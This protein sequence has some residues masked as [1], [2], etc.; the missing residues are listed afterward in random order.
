M[1]RSTLLRATATLAVLC[2][3]GLGY[4]PAAHASGTATTPTETV[5]PPTMTASPRGD[6][7]IAM[8]P[9]GILHQPEGRSSLVWTKD[10]GGE[11][12]LPE[13]VHEGAHGADT[14]TV[15]LDTDSGYQLKDMD[16]GQ[17][18]TI[19]PPEGD[20]V[21][22]NFGKYVVSYIPS[23]ASQTPIHI[24]SA[25][26]GQQNETTVTG[27]PAGASVNP[28]PEAGDSTSLVMPYTDSTGRARLALVDLSSGQV[29]PVFGNLPN[30]PKGYLLTG[31]YIGWYT[32][33]KQSVLHLLPRSQPNAAETDIA[34]SMPSI[35]GA[36][37]VGAVHLGIVGS[38]LLARYLVTYTGTPPASAALG[39]PVYQMP[40][41]GGPLTKL[42][43]A[44]SGPVL[45]G[46][47]S[48]VLAGGS[49]A[50]DWAIRR[51]SQAA[52]GTVA[53][54]QISSGA[55]LPYVVDGLTMSR[56]Q[57]Y[58][59][60]GVDAAD[61]RLEG[62]TVQWGGSTPTYGAEQGVG[63][64]SMTDCS[65]QASCDP[66]LAGADGAVAQVSPGSMPMGDQVTV[67]NGA[68]SGTVSGRTW[69]INT[70]TSG[71]TLV[72][73]DA[74]WAVENGTNGLQYL[75]NVRSGKVWTRSASAAVLTD[76]D[77]LWA[78]D[79]TPGSISLIDLN[80]R[81]TQQT[82]RTGVSCA[83]TE[84]QASADH[85]LYWSCGASGPAGV[86][87]L[88][89]GTDISV[90]SG[91]AQ[92]GDGYLV[93]HDPVAGKLVLTDFHADSVVTSGL[94]DLPA[95]AVPDD[96]RVSWAV[97]SSSGGGIA[98]VDAQS[99]IRLLDPH[100]PASPPQHPVSETLQAGEQLTAGHGISSMFMTL[101][102]QSDGNLVAY[103]DT[104][105]SPHGPALWS[106]NTSGHPGAYALMQPDGNLVVYAAGGGPT[107]GRALWSSGTYGHPGAYADFQQ[108]GNLVVYLPNGTAAWST[109]TYARPQTTAPGTVLRPSWWTYAAGN[110]IVMQLDGNLVVYTTGS[111]QVLWASNTSGHPGA[112][113]VMQTDGN[114][115]IYA[116]NGAALWSSRTNGH[117]GAYALAQD[118]GNFVV[119]RS[120]GSPIKGGALWATGTEG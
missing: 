41:A 116:P 44:S 92:L 28:F 23:S 88:A 66:P 108:D 59:T 47:S 63:T 42:L 110:R 64:P 60:S 83:P 7:V 37:G 95:G 114:L 21:M 29:V 105:A 115:V 75:G 26:G 82:V 70:G 49:S 53:S 107:T 58:V 73:A 24:L 85:W 30:G 2:A 51:I 6:G 25:G 72:D 35:P 3:T 50:S 86:I 109:G 32:L 71:G 40:L 67:W 61:E 106:S 99:N 94:A 65:A 14:D 120:G 91:L 5:I 18:E 12:R 90:P 46:P 9:G 103:L 97:D 117:P 96:R 87:D 45:Q 55:Q 19:V 79:S 111:G 118:D 54:S 100:I 11:T 38:T 78:A 4:P 15:L 62:R 102:M 10:S 112:H 39:Y 13:A 77:Y 36:A 8:G 48:I 33:G 98:Y 113:A 52:D 27:W 43:D 17:T 1:T 101:V 56:G 81:Q 16:T 69:Y 57:L 104:G 22:G 119:Y 68:N 84:L 93:R 80:T 89:T 31:T 20:L 74:D 34:V 76:S